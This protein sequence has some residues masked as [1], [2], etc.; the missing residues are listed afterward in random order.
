MREE[1]TRG[2]VGTKA[3]STASFVRASRER[4]LTGCNFLKGEG[5]YK[6]TVN[7]IICQGLEGESPNWMQFPERGR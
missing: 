5:R 4:A 6:G 1:S 3:Q 2:K 7:C